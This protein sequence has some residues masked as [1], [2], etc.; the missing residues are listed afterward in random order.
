MSEGMVGI[1]L[2]L[3]VIPATKRPW[4]LRKLHGL[5]LLLIHEGCQHLK[6]LPSEP[7]REE[8]DDILNAILE[9]G[10]DRKRVAGKVQ[11]RA[12]FDS[13]GIEDHGFRAK[14]VGEGKRRPLLSAPDSSRP[15][16]YHDGQDRA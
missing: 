12:G 4:S 9:R 16:E 1:L 14:T 13:V 5:D 3:I 6:L 8:R 7:R 2:V 11:F 10:E 15:R